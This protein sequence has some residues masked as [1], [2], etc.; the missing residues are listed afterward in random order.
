MIAIT[1]P[2]EKKMFVQKAETSD[3]RSR[4]P[5]QEVS[6]EELDKEDI[7]DTNVFADIEKCYKDD[8]KFGFLL[9][10]Y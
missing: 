7:K 3:F 9:L 5:I 8:G 6:D 4:T 1:E 2:V 10:F